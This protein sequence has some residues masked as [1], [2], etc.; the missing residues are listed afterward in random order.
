MGASVEW[1]WGKAMGSRKTFNPNRSHLPALFSVFM[2]RICIHPNSRESFWWLSP[3]LVLIFHTSSSNR[4]YGYSYLLN[5]TPWVIIRTG[6]GI[7]SLGFLFFPPLAIIQPWVFSSSHPWLLFSPRYFLFPFLGY[8]LALG[9]HTFTHP[10]QRF[11]VFLALFITYPT[12]DFSLFQ[13]LATI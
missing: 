5:T 8:Y 11:L 10:W 6:V 3:S 12:L 9:F 2:G 13:P 1:P 7:P 4:D